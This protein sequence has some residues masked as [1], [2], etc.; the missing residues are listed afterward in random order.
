MASS[1]K[2]FDRFTL[3]IMVI[4][5]IIGAIMLLS[6]SSVVGFAN[7]KDPYY[8]I[9]KHSLY[10]VMGI[11]TFIIGFKVPHTSYQKYS[12]HGLL[13][14]VFLL[15]LTLVPGVGVQLGGAKRWL[16]LVVFQ[17]QPVEIAKFFA[18]V[19]VATSLHNKQQGIRSLTKGFIPILGMI[20]V[21]AVFLLKQPDLGNTILIMEVT[22]ILL[23]LGGA[24]LKHLGGL[25]GGGLAAIALSVATHPYQLGRIKT[26][27]FP[28]RDPL[29]KSYH[30]I[31]SFI[32]I[33]S[34]GIF[35]QGLGQSKLKYFYLPL[36]YS[37]F[38][39]SIICEEGGLILASAV[40][41]LNGLLF[42]RGVSIA[43]YS[44]NPFSYFLGVGL[45]LLL[46][47]QA[48]IN[49]GVAIGLFPVKGVPLTFI[50]FGGT[51]LIMSMFYVGVLLNI[52]KMSPIIP[53]DPLQD[54][55]ENLRVDP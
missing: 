30:I 6:S 2:S 24:R 5:L 40:I 47:L 20:C 14:S 16:N 37:D 55:Q 10:L 50:S 23:F 48:V 12:L 54:A 52:S 43:F 42:Y 26:F 25:I 27:L 32:A 29:G 53:S 22:L 18:V 4:L 9:K 19:F 41:I 34:G 46:V 49:M 21:P 1:K 31:Q 8:Y 35:G 38:I 17:M 51:S 7:F 3:Y 44:R 39:F 28:W 45:T 36:Q 15:M 13:F 11:I 33:G